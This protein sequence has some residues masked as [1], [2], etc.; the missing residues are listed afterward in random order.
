M[1][2][3][4]IE[5][6]ADGHLGGGVWANQWI[7]F[8][9][10][11]LM[12]LVLVV[13]GLVVA[14]FLM[15][16]LLPGDV[17]ITILG[18][19]ATESSREL[20]RNQLGLD[21]PVVEQ[22]GIYALHLAQ[23]DLGVSFVTKE[24]VTEIIASRLPKSGA[25]AACALLLI[26]LFSVPLGL[27]AGALTQEGRHRRLEVAF[28]AVT[29]VFGA[30][31]QFLTATFLAFIFA[32]WLR[33]LPVAGSDN[34]ESLV[35]PTL[36]IA[37]SPTLILAR[38]VRVETLNVLAQDYVRTARSK[39]LSNFQIYF[40]H[41]LPNVLTAALTIGG[42]IFANLVGGAVLVETIFARVGLGTELVHSVIT[43]DYPVAQGIVIVLGITVVLVN[44]FVD[45]TLAVI[46]PRSLA[47]ES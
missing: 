12:S 19:E 14:T 43:R 20:V 39:W 38:I 30:L 42:L 35:L 32:V 37:I 23:G 22:F 29:S 41:V 45:L 1:A 21:K 3:V 8:L 33:L 7:R 31:P 6:R 5:S 25:L 2:A 28:T 16:R 11:R 13:L 34:W 15:V 24:P 47:A 9:A 40:R 10:R 17:V 36:S 27:V 44:S 26:M 18:T 46:D 4:A